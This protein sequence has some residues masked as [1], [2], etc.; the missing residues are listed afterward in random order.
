METKSRYEII[1]DL[2]EKKAGLL[3][4]RASIGLTENKLKMQV[5]KSKDEL[6]DFLDQKVIQNQNVDDQLV[7]IERSLDRLNSQKK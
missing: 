5:E 3:N 4:T 7:S 6:Q 2:E 1:M